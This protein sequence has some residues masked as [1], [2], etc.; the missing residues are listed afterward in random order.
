[1][2]NSDDIHFV[3]FK[4]KQQLRIKGQIGSFICNSRATGEE[5][6]KLLLE[7]KF[8]QSFPWHYDPCGVIAE[9]RLRNKISPYAH[10]PKPEIE[11][12]MNQ[13]EWEENT[14]IDTEQQPPSASI[15]QTNT[16]QAPAEKR[17]R[18]DVSPSVTEVSADDFQVY[19]K[20]PKTSHTPDRSGGEETQS[21]TVMEGEHSLFSSGIQSTMSTSSSKK[22]GDTTLTTRAAQEPAG[23]N[24]FEKYNLIKKKNEMLTNSTY[25]QFWK[26]TST[27]QHRLLST[28]D[29]EKG[30]MHMAYLQAQVPHPKT[31]SDYKRETFEFDVAEVHPA[32]QM[33]LHRQTGEMI[34]STLANTSTNATK[35]QVSLN[36]VQTQLKLE[37]VSSLAKDNKI[38][39]L[40]E[41]VLRIGYDPSNIKEAEELIKKKNADIASL[42][43]QLKISATEDPQA[44]EMAETE[45]QKEEML[46]LI[47]EQNAQIKEMEAEL[48][49]LVK[50]KEQNVPMEVIPLNAVPI[51]GVSTTTTTS[52]TT[53]EI[54]AATSVTAPDA[55]EKLA[56][57]ME[58]MT[59]QGEE[60]RKLHEEIQNLQKMKST[61]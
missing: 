52:T 35:L 30:R 13:T 5:A 26:Q 21:T 58:D 3:A 23:L 47:M 38:K 44:K 28:F 18:K 25:A 11:K 60:I 59:L 22:Q 56:K 61:F 42:R 41:L 16:P 10:V 50:E 6:N 34:F 57:A 32:D 8:K 40:E 31:I 54:P 27:T 17:P 46:K 2:I 24:L 55:A 15:S 4:K 33:D 48:D 29:T 49:K 45:G 37:K 9:T 7:M 1:M 53:G 20:R 14:L 12:F 51:T 39:S 19:R 43:K 36:N